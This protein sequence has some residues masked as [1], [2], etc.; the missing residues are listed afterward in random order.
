MLL[1]LH[2]KWRCENLKEKWNP[3]SGDK[4]YKDLD[5]YSRVCI[6]HKLCHWRM[7]LDDIA[8]LLRV[9]LWG[10][11]DIPS[12]IANTLCVIGDGWSKFET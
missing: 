6:M 11:W 1:K 4:E 8:D 2:L 10:K 5:I 7:E 9:R 12:V 3:L